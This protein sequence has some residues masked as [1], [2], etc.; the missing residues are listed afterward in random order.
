MRS[1]AGL[2]GTSGTRRALKV[3]CA[4]ATLTRAPPTP[5]H[6]CP[7]GFPSGSSYRWASWNPGTHGYNTN[8][9]PA[10]LNKVLVHSF[11]FATG[12]LT[13]LLA[14]LTPG[15]SVEA[16]PGLLT[17]TFVATNADGS[18]RVR[19]TRESAATCCAPL[20]LLA[21]H[22]CNAHTHPCHPPADPPHS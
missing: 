1:Q 22:T 12:A 6:Q 3:S 20:Q 17:V 11:A 7:T 19:L 9:D 10:F 15:A 13:T 2:D 14:R 18:A 21:T 16:V 5:T 4:H 8:T